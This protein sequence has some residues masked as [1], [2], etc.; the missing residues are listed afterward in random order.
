MQ[1]AVDLW[2][3]EEAGQDLEGC[4]GL[5]GGRKGH[6]RW[7]GQGQRIGAERG[8][9]GPA[10]GLRDAHVGVLG[11]AAL[12]AARLGWE[13]NSYTSLALCAP[14][15]PGRGSDPP[16][17]RFLSLLGLET[18]FVRHLVPL[19]LVEKYSLCY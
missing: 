18:E 10:E 11:A 14:A 3:S 1:E 7:Q 5:V 12:S 17:S 8:T 13:G 2:A 9:G 16:R 6:L 19:S 15:P 4:E